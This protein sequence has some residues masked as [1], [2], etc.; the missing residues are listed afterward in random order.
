MTPAPKKPF[1]ALP[2][3]PFL[4]K[5][6]LTSTMT[7]VSTVTNAKTHVLTK[8]SGTGTTGKRLSYFCITAN[9]KE[10]YDF[11]LCFSFHLSQVLAL[12]SPKLER[13]DYIF[14]LLFPFGRS[15]V[16]STAT[17][18]QTKNSAKN[19]FAS[20]VLTCVKTQ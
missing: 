10:K 19:P 1:I 13:F 8:R 3:N 6:V 7:S 14:R 15:A 20:G 2:T 18:A 12:F 4:T 11:A 5:S 16:Q 17:F 9:E